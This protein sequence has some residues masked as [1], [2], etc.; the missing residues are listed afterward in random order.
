MPKANDFEIRMR[1]LSNEERDFFLPNSSKVYAARSAEGKSSASTWDDGHA[2]YD[3]SQAS[4]HL[5]NMVKRAMQKAGIGLNSSVRN[6]Y[7]KNIS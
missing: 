3:V 1:F 5:S 7:H 2:L 6:Q 4:H